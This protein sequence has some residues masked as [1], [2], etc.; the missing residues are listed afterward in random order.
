MIQSFSGNA[1]VLEQGPSDF[2]GVAA[3]CELS[4]VLPCLDEAET[5]AA[6]IDR[7]N[8]FLSAYNVSGEVI[9]ADNGSTDGSL[10]IA[11]LAGARIIQI[12]ARGYGSA[13]IGGIRAAR[14]T[15]VAM[16]DAD[17][18]YDFMSLLPFLIKLRQGSDLVMGNRFLGGI[19]RGAMPRLHRYL[20]N[21]ALSFIGRLF[22]DAPIGDFH[23]GL[24]AFRRD[25][26]LA[27]DL[28]SPGME[29]ASEMVVKARLTKLHMSEVPTSLTKDGRSRPP[30]LRSWSDGW[31]HLK[32]LLL[33]SPRWLF[34]YP[35][36]ALAICAMLA[37]VFLMPGY[38]FLGG[39]RLGVHSLLFAAFG[40]VVGAQLAS[41]GLIASLF[42]VRERFWL[43]SGRLDTL[44]RWLSVD[45]GCVVGGLM[46]V[47]SI[48]GTALSVWRWIQTGYGDL[49]VE[50][51][52]RLVIPTILLG[53]LGVQLTFT[54]FLIGL[55]GHLPRSTR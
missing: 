8:R 48:L 9:V 15:F 35:G 49:D 22:Y 40:M 44:E 18:S 29:F 17:E 4:I 7:A 6:V 39:A 43:S 47:F 37:F 52:M 2:S 14:G 32:F 23:C 13:L 38:Q 51:Q 42:G 30:H 16:G 1:S 36:L 33:F 26:I 3:R 55:I 45:R 54:S 27:L 50:R 12:E 34:V 46:I 25:S 5:L 11:R 20:G 31:R 28:C 21:P 41:F 10:E 19:G 24:R 53:V